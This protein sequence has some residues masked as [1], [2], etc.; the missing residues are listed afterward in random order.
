MVRFIPD[1]GPSYALG[2]MSLDV[3]ITGTIPGITTAVHCPC[4]R[5]ADD[6]FA[7]ITSYRDA[8]RP[9]A[10][11]TAGAIR[12]QHPTMGPVQDHERDTHYC[13]HHTDPGGP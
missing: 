11:G 1:I 9:A 5:P 7:G 12:P 6:R 4:A 10:D 2:G 8:P 13:V 3:P